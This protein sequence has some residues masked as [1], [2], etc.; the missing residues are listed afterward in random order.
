MAIAFVASQ[1]SNGGSNSSPSFSLPSGF[2]AGQFALCT[3]KITNTFNA[4]GGQTQSFST[5]PTGWTTIYRDSFQWTGYR[6]LQAGDT[7]FSFAFSSSNNWAA[8][9]STYTG[10]DATNPVDTSAFVYALVLGPQSSEF[11]STPCNPSYTTD[12]QVN[13]YSYDTFTTFGVP[14]GTTSNGSIAGSSVAILHAGVQLSSAVTSTAYTASASPISYGANHAG[15]V[16]LKTSGASS[17]TPAGAFPYLNATQNCLAS[18]ALT[19]TGGSLTAFYGPQ[20]VVGDVM[21]FHTAASG[22]VTITP[23]SG[24]TAL[25]TPTTGIQTWYRAFQSGDPASFTFTYGTNSSVACCTHTQLVKIMGSGVPAYDNDSANTAAASTTSPNTPAITL[26]SANDLLLTRISNTGSG[27][28]TWS[29]VPGSTGALENGIYY[30]GPSESF[31]WLNKAGTTAPQV[32]CTAGGAATGTDVAWA[33]GFTVGAAPLVL[34]LTGQ[35]TTSRAGTV[36]FTDSETYALTGQK[37]TSRAG[38]ISPQVSIALTGQKAT[39]HAGTIVSSQ[40]LTRALTGQLATGH[41]GTLTPSPAI[42]LSGG[43]VTSTAGTVIATVGQILALTGQKATSTAGTVTSSQAISRT[44]TGQKATGS[45]GTVTA[46]QSLTLALTG[47]SAAATAGSP[48]LSSSLTLAGRR[49]TGATGTLTVSR[50]YFVALTGARASALSGAV[51]SASALH[52]AG[53]KVSASAGTIIPL[54]GLVVHLTGNATHARAGVIEA[55]STSFVALTGTRATGHA[56]SLT[57]STVHPVNGVRAASSAGD[58]RPGITIVLG[59]ARATARPGR[60]GVGDL[61]GQ[62]VYVSTGVPSAVTYA[63]QQSANVTTAPAQILSILP[64]NNKF[65]ST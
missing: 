56:G 17:T 1:G 60:L 23:P 57:H 7:T 46:T 40:A 20:P 22:A 64:P 10:V 2:T 55:T 33:M 47:A 15:Q 51:T 14:S 31:G 54:Q 11:V 9:V 53:E 37:A 44:L 45:A 36:T 19:S 4:A 65:V 3:I 58:I 42:S 24:W 39:G 48:G 41:A 43:K 34:A 61:T 27:G 29:Y 52:L 38:T 6:F 49:A 35:K 13:V 21:L 62:Q 26:A 25:T 16:L 18:G 50:D 28:K 30:S 63:A 59:G 32:H 12:F 5:L 8:L